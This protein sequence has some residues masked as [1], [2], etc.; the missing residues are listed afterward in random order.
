MRCKRKKRT[1]E[2]QMIFMTTAM[3]S[4]E[5]P[6][7]PFIFLAFVIYLF[8]DS[9]ILWTRYAL[10]QIEMCVNIVWERQREQNSDHFVPCKNVQ[11]KGAKNCLFV[12]LLKMKIQLLTWVFFLF[13]LII[14]R[15][16]T[17]IFL[18]LLLLADLL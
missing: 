14:L 10:K 2:I 5:D 18:C 3:L 7:H 12:C 16:L 9:E 8:G 15:L 1:N 17:I 6:N 13:P 11:R 4:C